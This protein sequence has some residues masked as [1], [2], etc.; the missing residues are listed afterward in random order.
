MT[1]I[2]SLAREF[3]AQP[4]EVAEYA[5]FGV[6]H[7]QDEVLDPEDEAAIREAWAAAHPE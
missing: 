4:H 1:T 2:A 3:R 7:H 5:E 6:A